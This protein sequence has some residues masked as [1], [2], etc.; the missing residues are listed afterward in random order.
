ML[1][2]AWHD[3]LDRCA[4]TGPAS[5]GARI[6]PSRT[7]SGTGRVD[8]CG[9]CERQRHDMN[10]LADALESTF[11]AMAPELLEIYRDL[12]RNPELSM[13]EHRTAGIA[14]DSSSGSATR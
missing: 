13:Q 4:F 7:R 12:H 9:S 3:A 5:D 8:A 2:D 14:A 6:A 10:P 1:A 11:D